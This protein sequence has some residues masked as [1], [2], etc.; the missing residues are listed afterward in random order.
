MVTLGNLELQNRLNEIRS[1]VIIPTYNNASSIVAV[2]SSVLEY[3]SKV[4][5]VND[6]SDDGT[7]SL[8]QSIK[9][10]ELISYDTNKGKGFALQQGF[11]LARKL[12]YTHSVS[13]D[14]DGQ[15]YASDLHLFF[16]S[17]QENPN[18]L[19]IGVRTLCGTNI[20]TKSNFANNFSN[21]WFRFISN[22]TL[23]DTQC[24][25]RG[26]P[27][28][29]INGINFFSSKYEFELEILVRL[30][31]KQVKIIPLP[32]NVYYPKPEDRV[33]H[34]R[35][36][37]DFLRITILNTLFVFIAILY[38]K[39]K[40]FFKNLTKANIIQYFD[41]NILKTK[42][43]N[44]TIVLSVMLGIFMGIVPIWG[45]QLVAAI[46]LAHFLKLNK[47]IVII[48]ANVSI[49]PMVPVIVFLSFVTGGYVLGIPMQ[50]FYDHPF[51]ISQMKAQI[52]Q[53]IIG[54]IVFAIVASLFFG[55]VTYLAMKCFRKKNKR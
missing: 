43:S 29:I 2:I 35:P 23:S 30:A 41:K 7:L 48:A 39:P 15:H 24:G 33:T 50:S 38:V 18:A 10:I 1:C 55:M 52:M 4:I 49:V 20:P 32:V 21:F 8:L 6:G 51:G 42:D 27:L 47:I 44:R 13:I 16:E 17:F 53:Y 36:F 14:A 11:E 31:W 25:Y 9:D 22:Q 34:F 37:L 46:A 26:Y 5:V 45:Y 54:S 12:G 28:K 3:T 19:L 40:F